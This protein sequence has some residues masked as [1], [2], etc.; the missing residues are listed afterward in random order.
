MYVPNLAE[1]EALITSTFR[2]S[3][4]TLRTDRSMAFLSRVTDSASM[5]TLSML[6]ASSNTTMLSASSSRDTKLAT[7]GSSMYW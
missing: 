1:S 4:P 6:C 2:C 5:H 7:F 3:L